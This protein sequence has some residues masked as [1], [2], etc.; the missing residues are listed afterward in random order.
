MIL[1][2]GVGFIAGVINTVSAGGSLITLPAL[3]FLGIPST[4]ANGT[5]RV[6]IVVQ[7]LTSF[8]YLR[9]KRT[10][11]IKRQ[12]QYINSFYT[13]SDLWCTFCNNCFR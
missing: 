11:K 3:L 5:N 12:R 6:A 9:P 10:G 2:I 4:E 1:L 7:S 13:G 8:F